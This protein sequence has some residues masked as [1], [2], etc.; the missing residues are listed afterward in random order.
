MNSEH[1]EEIF[2]FSRVQR[3]Q[4]NPDPFSVGFAVT[5]HVTGIG[6]GHLRAVKTVQEASGDLRYH[7]SVWNG[8]RHAIDCSLE[9]E[10]KEQERVS[11]PFEVSS[12][13][14]FPR[15]L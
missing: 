8:L 4:K 7:G 5:V 10:G 15:V 3:V 14:C 12:Y 6:L 1:W 2:Q 13:L 11:V 9:A